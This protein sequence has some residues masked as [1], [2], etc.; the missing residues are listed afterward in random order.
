MNLNIL[1]LPGDGIGTEVTREAVRVLRHVAQKWNHSLNLT[2]GLL[3]GIAI[4]QTGT[5]FPDETAR[6]ALAADAT[7]MGA[8]GLPEFD[9]VPPEKRPEKGLLGIRK[10]LGVYANLRPVRTYASLLDSSPLKNELVN[11]T[12][13]IIVRELTGGIYYGTPRGITEDGAETRSVNTMAY[14]RA[15]IERVTRMA[16][17]LARGRHKKLTS[18]DKSNVLETSQLWR[19]VVIEIAAE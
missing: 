3:G 10:T 9:N 19:R 17:H 16:F 5:P 15:E 11:G 14:T 12:D 8:V 1:V 7:L 4:H 13:M 18:V 6:L 2:E